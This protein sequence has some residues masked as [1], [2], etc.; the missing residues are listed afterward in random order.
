MIIFVKNPELGKVKTRLAKSIG[1]KMALSVYKK[2]MMHTRKVALDLKL[3][4]R[5]C[6]S[7]YIVQDDL[8]ELERFQ[9]A[10]QEGEKLGERMHNAIGKASREGYSKICVIGSDLYDLRRNILEEAYQ[11]LDKQDVVLGPAEDGGYYLIGV[12]A[13]QQ[14]LFENKNWGT[15]TVLEETIAD[16][17]NMKLRFALLP[18]MNDIDELGDIKEKDRAYLFS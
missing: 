5:V 4:K 9:K 2:L 7:N 6:Y 15:E 17:K 18:V 1:D 14:K 13:P 11:L 8:W 16:V 3:D 10:R 12:N